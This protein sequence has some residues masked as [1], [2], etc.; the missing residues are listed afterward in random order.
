VPTENK[1][2]HKYDNMCFVRTRYLVDIIE[3]YLENTMLRKLRQ[4]CDALLFGVQTKQVIVY[5]E[6][7]SFVFRGCCDFLRSC[8]PSSLRFPLWLDYTV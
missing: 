8:L 3:P 4:A 7:E 6:K 1:G 5:P 2:K